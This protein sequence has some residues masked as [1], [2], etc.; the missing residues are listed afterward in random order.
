MN[1]T[2]ITCRRVM[3]ACLASGVLPVALTIMSQ[4]GGKP[5]VGEVRRCLTHTRCGL[6]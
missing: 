2:T 3:Q 4:G 6:N 1:A 5:S